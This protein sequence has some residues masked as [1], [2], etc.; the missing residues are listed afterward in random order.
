[1]KYIKPY[2]IFT[3]LVWL[4]WGLICIFSTDTI[5]E[6]IGVQGLNPSGITDI[7]VMYGGVQ[8]GVGVMAA[9]ALY[10]RSFFRNLL[11]TLAF[12]GSC[13]ALSRS[14]GLAVDGSS[15]LYTW[16]VIAYEYFAAISAIIWLLVLPRLRTQGGDVY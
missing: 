5:A 2:L 11:Y 7:R 13:M 1:M 9:Y 14:Y 16:G 8:L 4:P 10:N 15:S 6:I 3:V 12:L